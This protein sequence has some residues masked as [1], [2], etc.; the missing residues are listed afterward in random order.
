[1]AERRA[2]PGGRRRACRQRSSPAVVTRRRRSPL[3]RAAGSGTHRWAGRRRRLRA[4]DSSASMTPPSATT[5]SVE[6]HAGHRGSVLSY[7]RSPPS[8]RRARPSRPRD[9]PITSSCPTF[10][11]T[12][13]SH[14]VVVL[15]VRRLSRIP[16][17]RHSALPTFPP[18][19]TTTH[20][21]AFSLCPS[22][23]LL[24]RS[25][26][27]ACSTK[28]ASRCTHIAIVPTPKCT[29]PRIGALRRNSGQRN[30]CD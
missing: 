2:P 14:H 1:M 20:R 8:R 30:H 25:C 16:C 6:A 29:K 11:S 5:R 24:S 27:R 28:S 19:L 26:C 3:S 10:T 21:R 13:C 17:R 15:Y 12:G 22:V 23:R 18:P 9:A 7:P 4:T